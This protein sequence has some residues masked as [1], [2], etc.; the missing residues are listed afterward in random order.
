MGGRPK[1]REVTGVRLTSLLLP[2]LSPRVTPPSG[3]GQQ[4]GKGLNSFQCWGVGDQ[5]SSF[6]CLGAVGRG[7]PSGL[8]PHPSLP[9]VPEA[10]FLPG[11]PWKDLGR[12]AQGTG[13]KGR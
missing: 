6:H 13:E 2:P 4:W 8:L 7:R 11:T 10:P 5:V 1:S 3:T 9:S 12:G